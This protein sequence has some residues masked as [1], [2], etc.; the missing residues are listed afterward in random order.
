MSRRTSRRPLALAGA[1]LAVAVTAALVPAAPAH[2]A[3]VNQTGYVTNVYDG[4]T[5]A[6]DIA[7]D[8]TSTPVHIRLAGIQAMEM[9]KYSSDPALQR[10]ECHAVPATRRLTQ[11]ALHKKVRVTARDSSSKS[12][13]RLRRVVWVY[14][15]GAWRD[16]AQIMLREGHGLFLVNR[17]EYATNR[18]VEYA[19]QVAAS[20]RY[21][22]WDTDFCGSGPYQAAA[23]R[24]AVQWDAAGNDATNVNGEWFRI[25]ND[26]SYAVPIGGWW[27]R[28][29]AYRGTLARG[30]TFPSWAKIPARGSVT[31]HVGKGTSSGTRFYMGESAPIFEN[32]T[33]SPTYIGD[34]GYLFDPQG[35]LRA[36]RMYP[37]RYAC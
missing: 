26:S 33:S 1:A 36:W 2:A 17:V 10:G 31:V 11:L 32:T 4:D 7:G 16:V 12:G 19:A 15:D 25:A 35:D 5:I 22:M 28:D 29:S 21:G 27:V 24:L 13:S 30:Y 9:T 23:L 3:S 6:V 37:C 18:G 34:G 20:R 14:V 8:G